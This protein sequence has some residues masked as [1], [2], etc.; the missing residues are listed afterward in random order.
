M[1]TSTDTIK[2]LRY[3]L[4]DDSELQSIWGESTQAGMLKRLLYKDSVYASSNEDGKGAQGAGEYL[5]PHIGLKLDDDEPQLRCSDDNTFA[6]TLAIVNKYGNA[7]VSLVNMQ[8][9][10]RLK[11]LLRDKASDLRNKAATLSPS[12]DLKVRDIAWVSAV[13]YD[14]KEQ[15]SERRHYI[16]CT[17]QMTVGD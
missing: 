11:K 12:I 1:S 4:A 16:I 13:T 9:K 15:G 17:V 2:S 3:Y 10:D 7:N 5:Y 6:V 8:T 14:D